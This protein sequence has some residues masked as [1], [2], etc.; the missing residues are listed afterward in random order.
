K[1]GQPL[2]QQLG[3]LLR[4]RLSEGRWNDQKPLPSEAKISEAASLSHSTVRQALSMLVREGLLVRERGRGTFVR[5]VA[6]V[7]GTDANVIKHR[8]VGLVMPWDGSSFFAALFP[9][10]E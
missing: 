10:V 9:G 6:H 7:Q 8:R 2:Y 3:S 4:T 5:P 1:D